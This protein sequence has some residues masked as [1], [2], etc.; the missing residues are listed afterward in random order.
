MIDQGSPARLHPSGRRIPE[1]LD[2]ALVRAVV[3]DFYA[4]V[5]RDP[6]IGPIFNRTIPD[7]EWP[8]HLDKIEGFWCPMLLGSR[9]YNGRPMPK[10][11]AIT[12]LEDLHFAR[13]LGL[14]RETV[15]RLCP[16]PVAQVFVDRAERVAHSFRLGLAQSRGVDSIRLQVMRAPEPRQ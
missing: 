12:D 14:F 10:H 6:L 5:R 13:W 16:R 11:L 8:S 1:G 15:E 3:D 7:E 2:D 9:S 4:K